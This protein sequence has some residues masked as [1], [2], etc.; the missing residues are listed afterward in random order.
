MNECSLTHCSMAHKVKRPQDLL[1]P[2]KKRGN[3]D[4]EVPCQRAGQQQVTHTG[5]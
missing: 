3:A 4:K 2:W 5:R 1:T